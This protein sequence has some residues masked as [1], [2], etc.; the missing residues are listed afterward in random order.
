MQ[1]LRSGWGDDFAAAG[2]VLHLLLWRHLVLLVT[3]L[4][5]KDNLVEAS[6]RYDVTVD[7]DGVDRC[8]EAVREAEATLAEVSILLRLFEDDDEDAKKS[9]IKSFVTDLEIRDVPHTM[10]HSAVW[11]KA[12]EILSSGVAKVKKEKKEK[13]DKK[14]KK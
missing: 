6:A 7:S 10:L 12:Q 2:R 4:K 3:A 5:Q 13:K 11:G 14:S 1:V 8:S 9:D